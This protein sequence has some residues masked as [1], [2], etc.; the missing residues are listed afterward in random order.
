MR[1]GEKDYQELEEELFEKYD[2]TTEKNNKAKKALELSIQWS[3]R[4]WEVE[5]YFKEM[6]FLIIDV[7]EEEN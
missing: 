2:V 6:L 5:E 1:L 4:I 7:D 3:S